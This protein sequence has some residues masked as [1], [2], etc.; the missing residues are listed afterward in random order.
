MLL[1]QLLNLAGVAGVRNVSPM[2]SGDVDV[3]CRL[4]VVVDDCEGEIASGEDSDRLR[5]WDLLSRQL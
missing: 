2:L 5:R 1:K 4:A 3:A